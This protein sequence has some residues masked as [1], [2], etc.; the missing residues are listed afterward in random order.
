MY[1]AAI[2]MNERSPFFLFLQYIGAGS[3]K[4]GP[5]QLKSNELVGRY[6]H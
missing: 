1:I 6:F 5:V 2:K 3:G 4:L